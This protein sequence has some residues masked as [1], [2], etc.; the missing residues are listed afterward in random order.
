MGRDPKA[1]ESFFSRVE[2]LFAG[3]GGVQSAEGGGEITGV[4]QMQAVV[5]SNTNDTVVNASDKDKTAMPISLISPD[6]KTSVNSF[7]NVINITAEKHNRE[8]WRGVI[9]DATLAFYMSS[10]ALSKENLSESLTLFTRVINSSKMSHLPIVIFLTKTDLLEPESKDETL[11]SIQEDFKRIINTQPSRRVFIC[12]GSLKDETTMNQQVWPVINAAVESVNT[13]GG[14]QRSPRAGYAPRDKENIVDKL[15]LLGHSSSGKTTL[16]QKLN[17]RITGSS[18]IVTKLSQHQQ[19]AMFM[20]VGIPK[21]HVL[22]PRA[23][24]EAG[25]QNLK[26]VVFLVSLPNMSD[27]SYAE[28]AMSKFVRIFRSRKIRKVPVVLLFNKQDQFGALYSSDVSMHSDIRKY[29]LRFESMLTANS[30]NGLNKPFTWFA[31][32]ATETQSFKRTFMA[33]MR[34]AGNEYEKG[35]IGPKMLVT[36]MPMSGKREFATNIERC[37]GSDPKGVAANGAQA[38]GADAKAVVDQQPPVQGWQSWR[39]MSVAL[40][41]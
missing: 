29:A 40:T 1:R 27:S 30:A 24:W 16:M 26:V 22:A 2:E 8:V 36:G 12:S 14:G 17:K 33:I 6:N 20:V 4:N 3:V 10:A 5:R 7:L 34:E 11:A 19:L 32:S 21:D 31:S 18:T 28:A 13:R 37:F 38:G 15:L 35:V 39:R 9:Q 41:S 23:V 25:I